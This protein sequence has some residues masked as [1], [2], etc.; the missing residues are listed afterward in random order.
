MEYHVTISWH[1][2]KTQSVSGNK[3]E[4]STILTV[5][6]V[7]S[8]LK[9]CVSNFRSIS[10]AKLRTSVLKLCRHSSILIYWKR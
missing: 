4:V 9:S 5:L 10:E 6:W 7:C 8:C 2:E 1:Q 3:K